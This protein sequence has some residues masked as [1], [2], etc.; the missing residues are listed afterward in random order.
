MKLLYSTPK[1]VPYIELD[2]N[3]KLIFT[4][5]SNNEKDGYN[6]LVFS[7]RNT[8]SICVSGKGAKNKKYFDISENTNFVTD[9]AL[10]DIDK[11]VSGKKGPLSP[12]TLGILRKMFIELAP[13]G[14]MEKES[15]WKLEKMLDVMNGR[16]EDNWNED[17]TAN[18]DEEE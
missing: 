12:I 6:W 3:N 11:S 7:G 5:L 4:S 13:N 14:I 15:L 10:R 2:E 17:A 9:M 16:E 8:T 1:N 18:G